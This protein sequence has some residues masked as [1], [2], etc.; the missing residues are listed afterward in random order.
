MSA[1]VFDSVTTVVEG[2]E[3][4]SEEDGAR[5]R[6]SIDA[7]I[8]IGKVEGFRSKVKYSNAECAYGGSS[9]PVSWEEL[10]ESSTP[11]VEIPGGPYSLEVD[12]Y[13]FARGQIRA[14]Y[15][16]VLTNGRGENQRVVV[17]EF[18]LAAY[19]LEE[20]CYAA[21]SE[22]SA[23]ATFI[24]KEFIG[25]SRRPADEKEIIS[26]PS[27]IMKI[28]DKRTGEV[29]RLLNVEDFIEVHGGDMV[30]WSSN[31]G[32]HMKHDMPTALVDMSLYS[33][34]RS[35]K[36]LL[37]SDLQGFDRASDYVITDPAIL[38]RP[39]ARRFMPTNTHFNIEACVSLLQ[40][41]R[42]RKLSP[43]SASSTASALTSRLAFPSS[44]RI[45]APRPVAIPPRDTSIVPFTA[46][47]TTSS[48]SPATT[49]SVPTQ[50][51]LLRALSGGG[52]STGAA[53]RKVSALRPIEAPAK[54]SHTKM[55]PVN[56]AISTRTLSLS[57][58][59]VLSRRPEFDSLH[60]HHSSYRITGL[61]V[62]DPTGC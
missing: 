27:R 21:Q 32:T 56:L 48:I 8:V 38:F 18:M 26:L 17:K 30:K 44:R 57:E 2:T 39:D 16:A 31:N 41:R 11:L 49:A 59:I 6:A 58:D 3:E 34:E 42:D 5:A 7:L 36:Q 28:A 51:D 54:G 14:A 55:K 35:N 46:A 9:F 47:K 33:Y 15:K 61:C 10:M 1:H 62:H 25:H 4:P 13:P 23:C 20:S 43:S 60:T 22:I 12:K 29:K 37:I 53:L 19:R 40:H 52:G 50:S 45:S 24:I